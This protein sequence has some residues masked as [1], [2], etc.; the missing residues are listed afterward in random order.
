MA[1]PIDVEFE[2]DKDNVISGS[3]KVRFE[4]FSEELK[5]KLV[6]AVTEAGQR[7]F[8]N[9]RAAAPEETGSLKSAVDSSLAQGDGWMRFY[10]EVDPEHDEP[11]NVKAAA[12]E[13]GAHRLSK[14]SGYTR[15]VDQIFG[16][17]SAPVEQVISPYSRT[18]NIDEFRYLRG[19]LSS[20]IE[21]SFAAA[22][23]D[24]IGGASQ[25]FNDE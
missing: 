2:I 4:N 25:A 15:T 8:E 12:L 6:V 13:Y 10:V 24:A 9:V 17:A 20:G 18:P 22:V 14:V 16:Q 21:A 19:G 23:E 5:Q 3:L 11:F 7:L 1:V